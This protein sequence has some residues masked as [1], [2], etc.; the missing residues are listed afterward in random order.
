[1][2]LLSDT[3]VLMHSDP[4]A[5]ARAGDS[6]AALGDP[7]FDPQRYLPG[8]DML[9]FVHIPADPDFRIGTRRADAQRVA[10]IVGYQVQNH[11]INDVLTPTPAF[12]MSRYL[13]TVG[14]FRAFVTASG[15]PL[16]DDETLRRPDNRPV[17]WVSWR[18][19][20]AYCNWLQEMLKASP[21][22]AD[23]EVARL[24]RDGGWRVTLPSEVEWEKAA[25]G[26]Q[27]NA[28]YAWGDTPSP[29]YANYDEAKIQGS[30]AVGCFPCFR[31]ERRA[32]QRLGMDAQP[33]GSRLFVR[34]KRP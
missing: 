16:G 32:W 13:V 18:E 22:F 11:E 5:R 7:R 23:S 1:M 26:G 4:V 34:F 28:I 19:A 24:V 33:V 12:Y 9:G 20:L 25:R 27:P 30:S 10:K 8:D 17:R 3:T 6:L 31:S 14:Q 15:L 2:D 21:L 29:N